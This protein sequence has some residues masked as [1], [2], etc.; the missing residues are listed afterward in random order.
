MY[1][2]EQGENQRGKA[3]EVINVVNDE[4]V[5]RYKKDGGSRALDGA[6]QKAIRRVGCEWF[7]AGKAEVWQGK[8]RIRQ[9][10][11]KRNKVRIPCCGI[12][13]KVQGFTGYMEADISQGHARLGTRHFQHQAPDA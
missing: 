5:R 3:A 6:L 13:S 8:E 9:F 11:N 7:A 2:I 1:W 10:G 4:R 12:T